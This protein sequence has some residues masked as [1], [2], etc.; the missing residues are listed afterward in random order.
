MTAVAFLD[1]NIL[2][3]TISREP[4]ERAKKAIAVELWI[5][6][7]PGCRFRFFRNSMC[8][9]RGRREETGSRMPMPRI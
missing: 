2:L 3:Y 4:A 7:T 9:R 6:P 5:E 8:R 1:T